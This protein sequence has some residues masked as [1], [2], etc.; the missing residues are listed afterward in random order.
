MDIGTRMF[1]ENE[2]FWVKE[3]FTFVIA[4]NEYNSIFIGAV[5]DPT[6]K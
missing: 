6:K 3:P 5:L 4:D 2:E 1:V